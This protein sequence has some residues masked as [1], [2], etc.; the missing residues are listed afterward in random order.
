[1]TWEEARAQF[2]VLE[3][4]AYLNAGSVGPIARTTAAAIEEQLAADVASGRGS[5]PRF[6]QLIA[7]RGKARE[8]IAALV[9]VAPEHVALTSSTS[10]GCRIVIAGMGLGPEDEIVT[11]DSEHFG[12]LGAVGS[13]PARVRVAQV[14]ERP[15][16]EALDAVIAELTPRTRLIALSHVF[17]TTGHVLPVEELIGRAPLLVDGAQ[18]VGAIPVDASP[19]DFYTVSGQK[20]LCGP[21]STGALIVADPDALPVALPSYF[22]Q[23]A[24]EPDG[25]FTPR[26]GAARFEAGGAP[27][28]MAGL[29]SALGT[30]PAG[31]YERARKLAERCRQLLAVRVDVVSEHGHSTLVTWRAEDA[32]ATVTRALEAGVVIREMPGLGWCR[33]SVGWWTNEDDLERLVAAVS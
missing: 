23:A 29:L 27:A 5:G 8:A 3:H 15:A 11:T 4:I 20:W 17:W 13:S 2:P 14:R 26:P 28:S 19:F 22:S 18:A 6:E 24:Y 9:G 16:A 32:P 21:D 30:A 7:N 1:M 33:A 12:L 10:E 25:S 31:R